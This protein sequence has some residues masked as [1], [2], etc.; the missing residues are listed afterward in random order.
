MSRRTNIGRG[1]RFTLA[2][3]VGLG[4]VLAIFAAALAIDVSDWWFVRFDLSLSQRNTL[5]EEVED[6]IDRLPEKVVIDV[7]YRPFVRPYD[8]VT[9]EVQSRMLNFLAVISTAHRDKFEVNTFGP[10]DLEA[11]QVRQGE[12]RVEGE[13]VLVFS[14][15]ERTSIL[16][17]FSEIAAIDWG[18]P[19]VRLLDYLQRQGING[20]VDFRTFNP[21]APFRPARMTDFQGEEA[22]VQ[23]LLKVSSGRAPKIYFSEGHGEASLEGTTTDGLSGLKRLLERDGFVVESWDPEDSANRVPED[24]AVVVLAGPRQPLGEETSAAIGAWVEDG[25]RLLVA[26]HGE[27]LEERFDHGVVR[28]M[29]GWGMIAKPG[30]VCQPII[31][32][33]GVKVTGYPQCAIFRIAENRMDHTH[34]VAQ[35]ERKHNRKLSFA[36]T[37]AIEA[38]VVEGGRFPTRL[39]VV[40]PDSWVD[41][42]D[43]DGF[44]DWSFDRGTEEKNTN[45]ALL[46]TLELG[47]SKV[48]GATNVRRARIVG[49][50]SVGLLSNGYLDANRHFVRNLFNWLAER[51]HRLRVSPRD[52]QASHLELQRSAAL[53]ILTYTLWVG[54]PGACLVMG[55]LLGWRRRRA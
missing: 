11:A 33:T 44:Y 53:P 47:A 1:T 26:P 13:N 4:G 29:S 28:L 34:E 14:C 42:P 18:H 6:V 38:R 31:D 55:A 35:L 19:S 54:F 20:V 9:V 2:M 24:A 16:G 3:Q 52:P 17:F 25:G 21:N 22:F 40:P 7:F 46:C 45:L 8:Q 27:E 36:N 23:A 5:D 49:A 41:L 39:I 32:P 51:E 30:V 48:S 15:G 12:L 10:T 37:P 50:A 43:P